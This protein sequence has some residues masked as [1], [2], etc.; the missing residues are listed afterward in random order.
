MDP[1]VGQRLQRLEDRIAISDCVVTYAWSID[2][3]DWER[4]ATCFTDPVHIDFSEAGMPAADLPRQD[5]VA[6]AAA[7]LGGFDALQHLS[8]NHLI[9][10][11]DGDPDRA[12]CRSAM[13]AQHHLAGAEG[14]DTFVMRGAYVNHM[15]RSPDGWRIERLVQHLSWN[16]GNAALPA[17]AAARR[18]APR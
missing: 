1:D 7:G 14:G 11:D 8:P 6:F 12:V 15:R 16:E 18:E 17:L 5:F 9:A 3:A 10:F 2:T 4:F 13:V